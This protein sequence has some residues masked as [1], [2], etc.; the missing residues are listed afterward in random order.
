MLNNMGKII[1]QNYLFRGAYCLRG[2]YSPFFI[3]SCEI[4]RRESVRR[5]SLQNA[6]Q[7]GVLLRARLVV[8]FVSDNSEYRMPDGPAASWITL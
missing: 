3:L 5:I 7:S 2:Y 8:C 4:Y 1:V 6:F